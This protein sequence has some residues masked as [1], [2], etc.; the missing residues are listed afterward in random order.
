MTDAELIEFASEFREGILD[1]TPSAMM[2][3][4]IC[5]PLVT[6]LNMIGVPC[7]IAKTNAIRTSYGSCNHVW[8]YLADGRVLD[9]AAD[10]FNDEGLA[11]PPVYL[12]RKV[13]RLHRVAREAT[14]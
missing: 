6:L 7:S 10:Q 9:P 8:I 14:P 12:G 13:R 11:L 5:E 3:G 2:C 4:M 1:G